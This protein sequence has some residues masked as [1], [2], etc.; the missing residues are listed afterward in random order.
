MLRNLKK[1]HKFLIFILGLL[2]FLSSCHE[3]KEGCL[4]LYSTNYDVTADK[5]CEDCCTYPKLKINLSHKIDTS[6]TADT[7]LLSSF[8]QNL[9]YINNL[10]QQYVLKTS[11]FFVREIALITE[12][13]QF[14][15]TTD[16]I[17]IPII[18][19]EYLTVSDN[20][21]LIGLNTTSI[22]I[23][24]MIATENIK[25]LQFYI[26][27]GTLGN[28][29]DTLRLESDDL[30]SKSISKMYD[31]IENNYSSANLTYA[32]DLDSLAITYENLI[33]EYIPV[34]L[35]LDEIKLFDLG[36]DLQLELTL[37]Y[38]DLFFDVDFD[39]STPDQ[40]HDKWIENISHSFEIK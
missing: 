27:L 13:D 32:R 28:Q 19:D 16:N 33:H 38:H 6:N 5:S 22:S 26:G 2:C 37:N 17:K 9:A 21:N 39:N 15:L 18:N 35:F 34:T 25:G 10:S 11:D 20:I 14:I 31:P 40:I 29:I 8:R 4:D 1:N 7:V 23:E 12:S 24:N 36:K 30:L 3:D